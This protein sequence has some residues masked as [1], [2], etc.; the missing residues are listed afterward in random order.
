MR[1]L[2]LIYLVLLLMALVTGG[3]SLFPGSG[4][5][6]FTTIGQ[7]IGG[8]PGRNQQ[9]IG[10]AP[11]RD[12]CQAALLSDLNVEECARRADHSFHLAKSD[13]LS[14]FS[15]D[16]DTA[17]Y[18]TVRRILLEGRLPPQGAVRIEEFVNYFSYDYS[19]PHGEHP[20]SVN[21]DMAR[22]PWQ[23]QHHLVRIGIQGKTIAPEEMPPRKLPIANDVK[24]QVEFNP[25]QVQAYRLIGYE[26][27]LL[28]H[29][30]CKD[31]AKN[32][33]DI[34]A[35]HTVTAL[36]EIVPPGVPLKAPITDALMYQE[37]SRPTP[38]A[39]NKELM[40]VK[41]RYLRPGQKQ[42]RLL[43]ASVTL[44]DRPFEAASKDFR[45]AAAV[46]SFAMLLR[47]SPHR[48]ATGYAQVEQRTKAVVN[49]DDHP[50]RREFLHLVQTAHRLAQVDWSDLSNGQVAMTRPSRSRNAQ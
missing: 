39:D 12:Q 35:G 15:I 23:P 7:K 10:G 22:C 47:Q 46:A 20:I 42:S 3:S 41:V 26:N 19:A 49:G 11:E 25:T 28:E 38:Q 36:Y 21:T 37:K 8:A 32:A 40:T 5:A 43:T 48:G 29:H 50:Q 17:S 27:H 4:T 31:D 2:I 18:T 44:E 1:V 34:G 6:K 33:E 9:K 45:F 14:T 30:D 24:V 16:V 13:P